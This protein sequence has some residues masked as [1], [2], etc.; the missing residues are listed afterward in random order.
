M[1]LVSSEIVSDVTTTHSCSS[2]LGLAARITKGVE[3]NSMAHV[4][5]LITQ[6][7]AFRALA[8]GNL[9]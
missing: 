2:A 6:Q 5:S 9:E 4:L 3:A 7:S 1:L 8:I